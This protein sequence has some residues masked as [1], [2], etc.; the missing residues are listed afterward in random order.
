MAKNGDKQKVAI[1]I[2]KRPPT[3]Q[4]RL[5]REI[6]IHRAL[7]NCPNIIKLVDYVGNLSRPALILELCETQGTALHHLQETLTKREIK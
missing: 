7:D 6:L 5:K 4:F 2:L 3:T 1:K